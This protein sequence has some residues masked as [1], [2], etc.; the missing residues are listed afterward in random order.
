MEG[1]KIQVC[2][3]DNYDIYMKGSA[4]TICIGEFLNL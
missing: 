3:N 1:G 2:L 4:E